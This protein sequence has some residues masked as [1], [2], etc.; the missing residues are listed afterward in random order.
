MSRWKLGALCWVAAVSRTDICARSAE[1]SSRINPLCGG[2]VY[3]INELVQAAKAWQK[4]TALKRASPSRPVGALDF[5][6]KV[7]DDMRNRGETAQCGTASLVAWSDAAFGDQ[8]TEGKC[9]LGYVFGLMPSSLTAPRQI[10]LRTSKFTRKLV[11]SGLG[12]TSTQ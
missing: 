2:D 7:T 11:G 6:G 1:I 12:G 3:R 5:A 8:L 4:A 10:L 9:R